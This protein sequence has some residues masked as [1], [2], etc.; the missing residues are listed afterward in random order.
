MSAGPLGSVLILEDDLGIAYLQ[1]RQLE[2]A[3]Y[4]VFEAATPEKALST[5]QAGG[6]DL[7]VLDYALAGA[8]SGIEFYRQLQAK[9]YS[10]PAILVTGF[11]DEARLVEAL[12]AGVRDFLPKAAD[13]LDLL[14]STVERVMRQ[15]RAERK[16]I[17]S[18]ELRQKEERFRTSVENMLDCFG[19]YS[20][21]RGVDGTIEDFQIDY[22]NAAGA[23]GGQPGGR[24]VGRGVRSLHGG[25]VER[26]L[27]S[28]CCRVVETGEPLSEDGYLVDNSAQEGGEVAWFDIRIAKLNDGF[29]STWRN[30][31]ERIRAEAEIARARQ[32]AENASRAKDE[33]L[34]TVSHELRTPLNAILGWIQLL[35]LDD[36]DLETRR[37]AILTIERNAKS[38]ARLIEDLID[39]SRIVAGKLRLEMRPVDLGGT[40]E[41]ALAAARPA[42]TARSLALDVLVDSAAGLVQGDPDRLQQIVWNL[43]SNAIKFTPVNGRV[44]I[45]LRRLEAG[46]EIR[47][48]DSGKGIEPD[49]LPHVFERFSQADSSSTRHYSGLGLGLAITRHL[50][51]LHGGQIEASSEGEGHGATFTVRLPL[52][53][54]ADAAARALGQSDTRAGVSAPI[55]ELSRTLEGITIVAVDDDPDAR[56]LMEMVLKLCKAEVTVLSNANDAFEAL[57]RIRPDVLLS[58]IEMP[59]QDGYSL[60]RRV[61]ALPAGEGGETPAA[62]L[63]AYA[64]MEDQVR[65]LEAG[66]QY[67]L[68]KPV[69][70]A[71]LVELVEKLVGRAEETS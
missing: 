5:I 51:E 55:A 14:A 58:D 22:T 45:G 71:R 24:Q 19:I 16:A 70:A 67:H 34:A 46:V 61:R 33:F 43:L 39:I 40:I 52:T 15:V 28:R 35:A 47:V 54:P 56:L 68:P 48:S 59:G 42:A 25:C 36:L 63:T 50:V 11:S 12:R 30:V 65:A 10:L 20:A 64:R 3:G 60:I 8:V 9:G 21:Q 41:A 44:R 29:V 49:F 32:K 69:E 23:N 7:V 1:R 66:F 31:S 37:E 53:P 2:R 27:F 38:Q 13:F 6:I 62:A 57:Q 18:E 17:E 26:Q 4:T